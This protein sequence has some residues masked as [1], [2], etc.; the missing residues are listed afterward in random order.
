[1]LRRLSMVQLQELRIYLHPSP[2]AL[3]LIM[4]NKV[5]VPV[6]VLCC[7]IWISFDSPDTISLSPQI[8]RIIESL[9]IGLS[10]KFEQDNENFCQVWNCIFYSRF[11]TIVILMLLNL[12]ITYT[13]WVSLL[14]NNKD[15]RKQNNMNVVLIFD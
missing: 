6:S 15:T 2:T 7:W 1:M 9:E 8:I 10:R 3:W 5:A 12:L 11:V 14:N 4:S 13:E